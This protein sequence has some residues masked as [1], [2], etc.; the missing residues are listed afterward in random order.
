MNP[1]FAIVGKP[2]VGK[3]TLFNRLTRSRAAL[4]DA[5]AGL[6]RDRQYGN[7]QHREYSFLVIDTGGMT[8][9]TKIDLAQP[10]NEQALHGI[11]EADAVLLVVDGRGGLTAEDEFII[12]QLRAS[13]KPIILVIN[14]TEGSG[15]YAACHDFYRL[16]L[17]KGFPI[18]ATHGT[19]IEELLNFILPKYYDKQLTCTPHILADCINFAV[20]GRPNVGKSSLVNQILGMN[21]MLVSDIP[22]TTRDSIS[23]SFTHLGQ[24]YNIIDTAGVRRRKNIT[25]VS[26]K[27]SI[28]KSLAT[29]QH[30]HVVV[31]V[32]T[33]EEIFTEQ[34]LRLLG[35]IL[36]EGKALVIAVN[37][38][39]KIETTE[40][41]EIYEELNRKLDFLNATHIEYI[42]AITGEHVENL[43][44]HIK[45]AYHASQQKF[46][47]SELTAI[48]EKAVQRNNPPV[49]SG[50]KIKL[51]Y[52]H[53]GGNNPP[54][55][56]IHGQNSAQLPINYKRYLASFYQKQLELQG[57]LLQLKFKDNN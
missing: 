40:Y 28:V 54:L 29:I 5:T 22:G 32:V 2:N 43:I 25:E 34:D 45:A 7:C 30:A 37:K 6:T 56:V 44:A 39:D 47:T 49:I 27:F 3:S 12:K 41:Q 50:R 57:T 16:G 1:I 46:T 52:A 11:N 48:L 55:I 53:M 21:R 4:V 26:E 36:N 19:G 8:S 51:R 24:N 14:K 42:S 33:A 35:L 20:I 38:W 31:L 9:A 23:T 18:S 17:G 10:I 13:S 15:T